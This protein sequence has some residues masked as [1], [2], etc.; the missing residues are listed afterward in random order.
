MISNDGDGYP[1]MAALSRA[2]VTLEERFLMRIVVDFRMTPSQI[3]Q[4]AKTWHGWKRRRSIEA[5]R[6]PGILHRE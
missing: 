3:E 1:M 5:A 4:V 2:I 6:P